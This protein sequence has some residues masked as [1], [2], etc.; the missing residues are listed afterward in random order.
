MKIKYL[1]LLATVSLLSSCA[2]VYSP[3]L[4]HQ[5][6]AYQ[7]KP[8]SF[9]TLKEATYASAGLNLYTNY[10][11]NDVITSGQVDISHAYVFD[12][13]NFSYGGFGVLGDYQSGQN[14][15]S[16]AGYFS[17][18]FFGAVG[19]RM[20]INA[21]VHNERADFRFIGVEAA[22]S[23]EF[24]DYNTLRRDLSK[25]GGFYVDDRTDLVSIG[26]T[27]EVIFHNRDNNGFQHGIRGFLGTTLGH[28]PLNDTYYK[29]DTTTEKMFRALFP[30]ASYYIQF[31]NYFGT[32]E[33]GHGILF[34]V[35]Y[36]F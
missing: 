15:K 21:F 13:F 18:R 6:I 4:F 20:S 1:F 17:D 31:K 16:A 23:H 30:K 11:F 7:P 22:Y 29:D 34:R 28:D 27:T 33:A 14:N 25:V 32:L 24:G 19:G 3:A 8:A 10:N 36:K 26:L 2:H 35:G 5:D 12:N 9:D